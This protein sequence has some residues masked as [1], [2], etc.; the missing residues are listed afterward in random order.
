M[1]TSLQ[2]L[3]GYVYITGLV[4]EL[5]PDM[6]PARRALAAMLPPMSKEDMRQQ[7]AQDDGDEWDALEEEGEDW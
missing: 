5:Q 2:E 1:A 3:L 4:E 7:A 6:R